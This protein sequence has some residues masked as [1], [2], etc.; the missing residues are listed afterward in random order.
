MCYAHMWIYSSHRINIAKGKHTKAL[1]QLAWFISTI[2]NRQLDGAIWNSCKFGGVICID[3]IFFHFVASAFK[4][5]WV[6][7]PDGTSCKFLNQIVSCASIA[8]LD[9]RWRHFYCLRIWSPGGATCI[10][11]KFVHLVIL[12]AWLE[13]DHQNL[14]L[15]M[16]PLGGT[17]CFSRKSGH[18]VVPH[19]HVS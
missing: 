11:C 10:D 9:T 7:P 5:L 6:W 13:F 8:S 14:G 1:D 17:T 4:K 2:K 19:C 16:W 15:Q 18:Q 3:C 12:A